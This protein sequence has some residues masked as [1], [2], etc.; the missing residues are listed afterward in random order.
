MGYFDK[1]GEEKHGHSSIRARPST[2]SNWISATYEERYVWWLQG[3]GEGV[4]TRRARMIAEVFKTPMSV[5]NTSV[6]A[7][8]EV[9]GI[10]KKT[11]TSIYQFLSY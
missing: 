3:V 4:S 7:L 11:A 6:K 9:P 2:P 10:G 8:E 1:R 5:F